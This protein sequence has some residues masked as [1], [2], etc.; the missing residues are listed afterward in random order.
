MR[1]RRWA[2]RPAITLPCLIAILLAGCSAPATT[3]ASAPGRVG[4]VRASGVAGEGRPGRVR[5]LRARGEL[6][7]AAVRRPRRGQARGLD[8]GLGRRR[9]RR[10]AGP[11]LDRAARRAAAAAG[12]QAVD[13][14]LDAEPV[15]RQRH[16]QHR[17]PERDL[18]TRRQARLGAALAPFGLR[19]EPRRQ[20]RPGLAA[21]REDVLARRPA[22]A[23]RTR[24]R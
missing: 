14:V 1:Q 9:L 23:A 6:A 24:S 10:D 15:A 22:A 7:A 21:P 4:A 12:R 20:D 17:R 2:L 18:R 8:L 5:P 19:R 3:S 16:R 13:A 11:H